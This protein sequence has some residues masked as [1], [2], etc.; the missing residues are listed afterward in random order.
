MTFS[1]FHSRRQSILEQPFPDEWREI[2]ER[3]LWHYKLLSSQERSRLEDD[4]RIF[5]EEK[6][7]EAAGGLVMT[8]EIQV[9]ISAHACLLTLGM[10]KPDYYPKVTSIIVYPA[11]YVAPSRGQT[12][13]GASSGLTG[14]GGPRIYS[15]QVGAVEMTVQARL[16]EAHPDGPVILS[17]G[18]AKLESANPHD[19]HNVILHEFAH[20]LDFRNGRADGVPALR[21]SADYDRWAAVMSAEFAKLV[22]E[23][24]H[25]RHS[26]LRSYG[27]T[28]PAEFFAVCTEAFFER[29]AQLKREHPDLYDV[30]LRFYGIDWAG[31]V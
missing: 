9:T 14:L 2:V 6:Y 4:L 5:R 21:S 1:L 12:F 7:W 27:A 17:W 29:S 23:A 30:L 8:D 22:D 16:G 20:E 15:P 19:G 25:F 11:G 24:R 28:N 18:D 13:G 10:P 26:M 3:N 31:R